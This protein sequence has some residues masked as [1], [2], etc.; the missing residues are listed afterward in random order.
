[1]QIGK[2]MRKVGR[3]F[4]T[5]S[6]CD[7]ITY[8]NYYLASGL[9]DRFGFMATGEQSDLAPNDRLML[10]PYIRMI[11]LMSPKP[12]AN[13]LFVGVDEHFGVHMYG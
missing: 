1:M 4:S 9:P 3:V 11:R 5:R 6:A 7:C 10:C 12:V 8:E 2:N 13:V